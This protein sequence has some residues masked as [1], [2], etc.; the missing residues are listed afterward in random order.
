MY[1]FEGKVAIVTGGADGIGYA[2]VKELLKNG[3]KGVAIIDV[4]EVQGNKALSEFKQ[5]FGTN[6]VIFICAD[7]SN[8]IQL[9]DAFENT[10]A[11]FQQLDIVINNA[12]IVN[13]IDWEKC[14]AVN[15][16]AVIESSTLA[17]DHYFPKYKSGKEGV[18]LNTASIAAYRLQKG[19]V[20]YTSTK[21]GVIG[22][23]Q[24][25]G[26]TFSGKGDLRI[27]AICPD[28]TDTSLYSS[29]S[30][31]VREEHA[32]MF[33]TSR[34]NLVL[35]SPREIALAAI[36]LIKTADSGSVWTISEGKLKEVDKLPVA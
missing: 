23:T 5:E 4:N 14:V 21:C 6:R 36:K 26:I 13:E 20:A 15:F 7:V 25:V 28:A 9:R 29:A 30:E 24:Q 3:L 22:F 27:I 34:N 12:G 33:N 31:T 10:V 18:I 19:M 16:V 2:Y 1:D 11:A 17:I 8:K 35:Q 32:E